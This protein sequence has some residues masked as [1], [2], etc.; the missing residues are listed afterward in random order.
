MIFPKQFRLAFQRIAFTL[1]ILN[2]LTGCYTEPDL[3][4]KYFF[5]NN[6]DFSVSISAT[7]KD[8]FTITVEPH[9]TETIT[10]DEHFVLIDIAPIDN[11]DRRFNWNLDENDYEVYDFNYDVSYVITGTASKAMLTYNRNNGDTGQKT[12][13][14]PSS[15]NYKFFEDSFV[16]ISAQNDT[17]NGSVKVEILIEDKKIYSDEVFS[18][19]GIATASGDRY[20]K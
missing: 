20:V 5:K 8:I 3:S 18:A 6:T 16:Y 2:S 19:Y 1:V 14:I 9:K 15:V 4:E 17:N 7:G 11:T 10:T 13:N 12:V